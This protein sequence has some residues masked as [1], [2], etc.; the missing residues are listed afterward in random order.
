[1]C[2]GEHEFWSIYIYIYINDIDLY[3]GVC[4]Y[5]F[6][7]TYIYVI[8]LMSGSKWWRKYPILAQALLTIIFGGCVRLFVAVSFVYIYL[9]CFILFLIYARKITRLKCLHL[10]I[11]K[12]KQSMIFN[13]TCLDNNLLSKYT[14]YLFIYMHLFIYIYCVH[15]CL[16]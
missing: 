12:R 9:A 16:Y 13:W 7:C 14:K 3:V 1:M 4:V 11:L 10:K 2:G 5:L 15:A 8:F 6:I